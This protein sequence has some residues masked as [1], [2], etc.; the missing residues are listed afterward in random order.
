MIFLLSLPRSGSTLLQRILMGHPDIATCGE[1]WLALP[2]AL[3]DKKDEAYSTYGHFSLSN[4][5]RN[6]HEQ[7]EGGRDGFLAEAGRFVKAVYGHVNQ[8]NAPYFLD[9]TPRYYK[10]VPELERMFPD[11]KFI[12]LTRSPLSVFGSILNYVEGKVYRLPTW[13]QDIV[14]GVPALSRAIKEAQGNSFV[15]S[16]EEL[17]RNPGR[18]VGEILSFLELPASL[19]LLEGLSERTINLGD[20]HG[21]KRFRTI[22]DQPLE[23][24]KRAIDSTIKRSI[25]IDWLGRVP[26]DAFPPFGCLKGEEVRKC[27][28][29]SVS[30][31]LGDLGAWYVGALYFYNC[32]NVVRWSFRRRKMLRH[33]ALY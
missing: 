30:V 19:G 1:P 25:A 13:R 20:P 7:M 12:F 16:Y 22:T 28:E 26:E 6:L 21:E 10:V 31:R 18:A 32:L 9:K 5:I 33:P 4:S 15:V 23:G 29:H 8:A 24:W 3:M 2:L 14:E 11:A 27:R 17:V